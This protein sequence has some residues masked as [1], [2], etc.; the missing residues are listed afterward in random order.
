MQSSGVKRR[1]NANSHRLL[2]LH[3]HAREGGHPVS[4]SLSAQA[5]PSLEY[6]IVRSSRTM[7]A[8]SCL[9][10]ESE[11]HRVIAKAP[12]TAHASASS[13]FFTAG[14]AAMRLR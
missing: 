3:R 8:E 11:S 13:T 6:W 4:G 1:E 10:F 5:P 12:Q 7:T 2:T 14:R 9:T